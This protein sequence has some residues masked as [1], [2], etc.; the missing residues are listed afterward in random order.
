MED[1]LK[2]TQKITESMAKRG[3]LARAVK[4]GSYEE[5]LQNIVERLNLLETHAAFLT[6]V[7]FLRLCLKGILS[8]RVHGDSNRQDL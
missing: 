2:D 3:V 8:I 7:S 4:G 6:L 1:I 5:K